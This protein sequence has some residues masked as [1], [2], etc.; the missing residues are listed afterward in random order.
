MSQQFQTEAQDAALSN[1][2]VNGGAGVIAEITDQQVA[3][4]QHPNGTDLFQ[5]QALHAQQGYISF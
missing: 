2:L 3:V 1:A 4:L 5:A